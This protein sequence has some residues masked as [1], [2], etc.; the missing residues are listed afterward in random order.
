MM[1]RCIICDHVFS[2]KEIVLNRD[3]WF[4]CCPKCGNSIGLINVGTE[5]KIRE[6]GKFVKGTSQKRVSPQR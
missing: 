2:E 4:E 1:I 5:E 3:N 6:T